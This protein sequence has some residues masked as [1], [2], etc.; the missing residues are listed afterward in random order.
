M[1]TGLSLG[2]KEDGSG[3]TAVYQATG[4]AWLRVL[5]PF[6]LL[7]SWSGQG[8]RSRVLSDPGRDLILRL[9]SA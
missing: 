3:R 2:R 7:P 4:S 1:Q 8:G 5:R 9:A 6:S